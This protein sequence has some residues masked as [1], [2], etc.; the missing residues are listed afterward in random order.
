LLAAILPLLELDFY[1]PNPLVMM[2]EVQGD[3]LDLDIE[4]NYL[5]SISITN[6]Q[7]QGIH[8][9]GRFDFYARAKKAFAIV[10]TGET[11]KYGNILLKKGVTP[12]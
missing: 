8:R 7:I 6:P 1:E 11:A 10:M 9:I 12:F 5:K 2:A 4:K 3:S